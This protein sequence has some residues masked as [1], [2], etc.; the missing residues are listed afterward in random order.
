MR[1]DVFPFR[2]GATSYVIAD[3]L[4]ANARYLADWVRDMQLVLFDLPGGPSNLPTDAE[5]VELAAIGR[6][7]KISYTVH[8]LDDVWLGPERRLDHP[9]MERARQVIDLTRPLTPWAYVL[10]L[11]GRSVRSASTASAQL[12]SWQDDCVRALEELAAWAGEPALLAVENLEGY[13]PEFVAPVTARAGVSRCVDVGHLWLDGHDPLPYLA[14]NMERLRVVHLHGLVGGQDHQ[15]LA[16]TPQLAQ[17]LALLTVQD[18]SGVVTLEVFGE[19]D[20]HSSLRAVSQ[21]TVAL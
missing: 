9:S 21:V 11:D 18:F 10:H 16:P 3:G 8:L 6:E 19:E 20:F 4:V 17:V 7:R 15:A 13:P 5:V 12:A 2:L 1:D 14:A